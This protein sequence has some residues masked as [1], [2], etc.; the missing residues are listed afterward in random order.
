VL[1]PGQVGGARPNA[2]PLR[3][4]PAGRV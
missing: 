1:G 2:P 4:W 3:A